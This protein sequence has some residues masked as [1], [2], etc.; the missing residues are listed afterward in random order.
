M[1][2]TGKEMLKLLKKMAGLS[3]GKRDLIIIFIRM[4]LESLFLFMPI[5]I[6]AEDLSKN[7]KGCGIEIISHSI[8]ERID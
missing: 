4:V 1:P 5:K 8:K 2:L 3:E 7:F 6:L